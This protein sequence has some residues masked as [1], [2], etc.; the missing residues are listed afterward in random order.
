M[1]LLKTTDVYFFFLRQSLSPR[2]ECSLASPHSPALMS[3]SDAGQAGPKLE[4]SP[5]WFF[6]SPRKEFK[7]E[8]EVD[9]NS[10]IEV[11]VL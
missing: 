1:N 6:A 3:T 5:R 8:P 10:F 7:G 9:E 2:L 4:L 11:A